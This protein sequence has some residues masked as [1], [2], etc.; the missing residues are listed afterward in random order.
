MYLQHSLAVGQFDHF[1]SVGLQKNAWMSNSLSG[2]RP[3]GV[4][5]LVCLFSYRMHYPSGLSK[6]VFNDALRTIVHVDE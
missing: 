6:S 2:T 4:K 1:L 3:Q 5:K